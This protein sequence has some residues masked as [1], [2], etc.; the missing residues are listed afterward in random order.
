MLNVPEAPHF[1]AIS[2]GLKSKGMFLYSAVSSHQD[3]SKCFHF[4]SLTHLFTQTPSRLLWE[5]S[6]H[7]L[8]LLR[9]GCSYTYPPLSIVRYSFIQ[10]SEMQQR[11]VKK[12]GQVVTPQHRLRTRLPIVESPK[13]PE[14]LRSTSHYNL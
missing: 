13:H 5:A 1:V 11:R 3:R 10:P 12:H 2:D 7:M 9:E 8:Q 6:S 14:P 4:I